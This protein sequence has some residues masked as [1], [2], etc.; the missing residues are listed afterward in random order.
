MLQ[1]AKGPCGTQWRLSAEKLDEWH[2]AAGR[3]HD[4]QHVETVDPGSPKM[5]LVDFAVRYLREPWALP[6]GQ[7]PAAG[8][9]VAVP[10]SIST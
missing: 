4:Q 7:L 9:A 1:T 6:L 8:A 3:G 5:I 2:L 10:R